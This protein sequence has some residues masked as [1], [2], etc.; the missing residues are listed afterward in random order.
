MTGFEILTRCGRPG[1]IWLACYTAF[2]FDLMNPSMLS[3]SSL[4]SWVEV[5][6]KSCPFFREL[7]PKRL[8]ESFTF[9]NLRAFS[10]YNI[11]CVLCVFGFLY[12]YQIIFT[13]NII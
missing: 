12:V 9:V 11:N 10:L 2:P 6:Y 3:C 13:E 7:N 5:G 8:F 1:S 4:F